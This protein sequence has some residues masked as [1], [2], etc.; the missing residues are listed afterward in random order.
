MYKTKKY[1]AYALWR[2]PINKRAKQTPSS[3]DK[4]DAIYTIEI[5]SYSIEPIHMHMIVLTKASLIYFAIL[6]VR[7]TP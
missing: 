6:S 3:W 1:S 5:Q 7:Y 4:Y 2:A